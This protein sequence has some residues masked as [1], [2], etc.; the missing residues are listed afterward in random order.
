MRTKASLAKRQ[1]LVEEVVENNE[2]GSSDES[3]DSS[4]EDDEPLISRSGRKLR[5]TNYN[6]DD[7]YED[8]IPLKKL[9][10]TVEKQKKQTPGKTKNGNEAI[11]FVNIDN[12]VE[13]EDDSKPGGSKPKEKKTIPHSVRQEGTNTVYQ[14]SKCP[15]S[16]PRPSRLR[17]HFRKH[18]GDVRVRWYNCDMC[19]KQFSTEDKLEKH[20]VRRHKDRIK[21]VDVVSLAARKTATTTAEAPMAPPRSPSPINFDIPEGTDR[22]IKMENVQ[23]KQER[24]YDSYDDDDIPESKFVPELEVQEYSPPAGTVPIKMELP[25]TDGESSVDGFNDTGVDYGG[26]DDDDDSREG[27]YHNNSLENSSPIKLEKKI[28][29]ESFDLDKLEFMSDGDFSGT[30]VVDLSPLGREGSDH[31]DTEIE[32]LSPCESENEEKQPRGQNQK[33]RLYKCTYCPRTFVVRENYTEHIAYHTKKDQPFPC[34]NCEEQFL[35]QETLNT[36][37]EEEHLK[38]RCDVCN[39]RTSTIAEFFKHQR[40][41]QKRVRYK[42][43]CEM[44]AERFHLKPDLKKHKEQ[45]HGTGHLKCAHCPMTFTSAM[46]FLC[47]ATEFHGDSKPFRCNFC[48]FRTRKINHQ[49]I[50]VRTHLNEFPYRCLDCMKLFREEQD[51]MDHM[52]DHEENRVTKYKCDKCNNCFATNS[53]LHRHMKRFCKKFKCDKCEKVFSNGITLQQHLMLHVNDITFK[54]DVCDQAFARPEAAK[55]HMRTHTSDRPCPCRVC[56]RVYISAASR[57]NHE[58]QHL[59][60]RTRHRCKI[61]KMGFVYI[62]ALRE[63]M[64]EH[65]G[66]QLESYTCAKCDQVFM[67]KGSLLK[68]LKFHLF[69]ESRK[70]SKNT[71]K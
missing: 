71:R 61:C 34:E 68:H 7:D 23:V 35:T 42:Y 36:H 29:M 54:C 45:I 67:L 49:A 6:E 16:Y 22:S 57:T 59:G 24:S 28:K 38:P 52:R 44:C 13:N 31:T 8:T 21:V 70:R 25:P 40:L 11:E 14:C 3:E 39:G 5:K 48:K 69:T 30:E 50:H 41:H 64:Q 1:K 51:L 46:F 15:K 62:K 63:H 53:N 55:L 56:G 43:E 37:I 18:T 27:T 2:I 58:R 17:R 65:E 19:H 9:K 47:H 60:R 10:A 66:R 12:L 32:D 4:D 26:F 33:S 20:L